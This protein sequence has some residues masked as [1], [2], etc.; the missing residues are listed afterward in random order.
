[1][2]LLLVALGAVSLVR[3][4]HQRAELKDVVDVRIPII[5][6]LGAL[7][8]GVDE[9][10]IQL[11]NLA[12]FTSEA[13]VKSATSQ[14]AAASADVDVQYTT[15]NT[16]VSSEKGKELM[17]RMQQRGGDFLKLRDQYL[18]TLQQGQRDEALKLL[19]E[20]LRPAQ[21]AYMA[22]I[23]EQFEYQ[24][25]R[26]VDAGALAESAALALQRDVLIAA[27]LAIGIAIF[28]A[29]TIIRSITRPLA[30]AVE[31]ADRVA[32]GDLS[33]QIV[34][35][36]KDETGHLLSALQRMQQS[37][38]NTV[39]TV[40]QNAEGV[41]SASAQ[42]A[43]GNNDLS[44]RTEQQASALEETAASMEELGS[45]VRQNADNARAAN[46]LAVSASTVAVQGGDVVAE[47][48]ETMKG[49]NAS[50]NK[51][52]DIISVIDG[53]AFQ[54]NILALNAA[55][56]A[57]R[58]GEQGRGFAVVAGEVRN[59]AGRSAEAAKEIK[60]L[61]TASVERVEQGTA[62]V[63]KAGATMTE[64]VSAIR[65][66]TD[67]M[68]E[69]SAASS[70]QSAGVG[71]VGEAVTQM[72]QATQ[73]KRRPGGRNG[74]G[75]QRPERP[76]RRTGQRRGRVQARR[77]QHIKPQPGAHQ[78][79]PRPRAHGSAQLQSPGPQQ[80]GQQRQEQQQTRR[81]PGSAQ[82]RQHSTSGPSPQTGSTQPGTGQGRGQRRRL[83]ELLTRARQALG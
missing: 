65:R 50:S 8:D 31:A 73:Q 47:V 15:L 39:S 21:R 10:A 22:A 72:D 49:I 1:M 74:S 44:A 57:A 55:V 29:I 2:V 46:Q 4:A 68:G 52:A 60:A 45:T 43:S 14:I 82:G 38:V 83:G 53:I 28:L 80:P 36:S 40:R 62:L 58:A 42:I 66:V 77:Q 17:A 75:C 51:I 16:L 34:V 32:G 63:D 23:D 18:T 64:V 7:N 48:V 13:I 5:K 59:L 24:F 27:A 54:T 67:I 20:Q 61:I 69:I 30:Q 37:L 71:Q 3:S 78:R 11:R 41:A 9:Q 25:K 81:Q 33:G 12:I 26:T 6:A 79:S 70:E 76:G 56:E 19:E 35:Q